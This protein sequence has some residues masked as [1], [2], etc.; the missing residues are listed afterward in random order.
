MVE[1]RE[2]IRERDSRT[3]ER[4]ATRAE[5]EAALSERDV[6]RAERDA[7][8]RERDVMIEERDAALSERDVMR[9]E[10]D[11]AMRERDGMIEER[12]TAARDRAV[13]IR[14]RDLL[15][16]E[17]DTMGSERDIAVNRA[18]ELSRFLFVDPGHYY[19]PIVDVDGLRLSSLEPVDVL[20]SL[21]GHLQFWRQLEPMLAE[22]NSSGHRRYAPGNASF[23]VPDAM[24]LNAVLRWSRPRRWIEVGSGY[25]TCSLLDGLQQDP[26]LRTQVTLVE[27]FPEFLRSLLD[28]KDLE[29]LTLMPKPVQEVPSGTFSE[30]DAGDVL[31]IDSTHVVKTGSDVCYELFEILP[32][33]KPGVLVHFHDVFWPFEYPA[34]WI[35][36]AKRSW[37]ELYALRA[38]LAGNRDFDIV[39]FS[40]FFRQRAPAACFERH[41]L[42]RGGRGGSIWLRKNTASPA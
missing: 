37:N 31:F 9:A 26:E 27:P 22:W 24:I 20:P 40:D 32:R 29:G 17:R 23:P 30:L 28:P 16:S 19:S 5:R 21:E 15:R 7:A 3:A 10:R 33:L 25:S 35:F 4:D 34:E 18:A 1:D 39:F 41:P 12:D 14:E 11:A 38:F 8:T 2:T 36:E 13:M 42:F 6:M